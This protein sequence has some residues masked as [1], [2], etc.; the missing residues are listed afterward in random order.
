MEKIHRR[1]DPASIEVV[2]SNAKII[3]PAE[4]AEVDI[5]LEKPVAVDRFSDIPELGRF[6]LEHAGHPVAGGIIIS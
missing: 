6:V 2:E 4:V 5:R 1:F 3:K